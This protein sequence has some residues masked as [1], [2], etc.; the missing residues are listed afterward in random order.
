MLLSKDKKIIIYIFLFVFLGSINN[1]HFLNSKLFE[2]KSLKI[3]GLEQNENANLLRQIENIKNQNI[4]F[5]P[6]KRLIETL[7]SNNLIESF[8]IS[9]KYPSDLNI[10]VKKTSFLANTIIQGENFLIG[11]NKKLIKSEYIHPNLPIIFGNPPVKEF[12]MIK[13]NIFKSSFNLKDIRKLYFFSSKRWDLELANGTLIKLPATNSVEALNNYFDIKGL[14][15]FDNV[16]I[17]DMRIKKQI[18]IN[19][20]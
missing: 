18:I 7:N 16:K 12:F 15:Q 10:V 1:K 3:Y 4:F 14:S 20:Q 2:V 8:L 5:L 9:K 13:K 17:F 6:K 19:E 11:S